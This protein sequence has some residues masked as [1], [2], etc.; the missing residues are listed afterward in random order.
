MA[1]TGTRRT[2]AHMAATNGPAGEGRTG[3]AADEIETSWPR[4]E[5]SRW[6]RQRQT[7]AATILVLMVGVGTV[8]GYHW[9]ENRDVVTMHVGPFCP[10]V[11][12][13]GLE[14]YVTYEGRTSG[15]QGPPWSHSVRGTVKLIKDPLTRQPAVQFTHEGT[16]VVLGPAMHSC[17]IR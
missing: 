7:A 14:G 3:Q 11:P 10:G 6:A 13:F 5:R 8:A 15:V 1:R 9:Y 2:M 12:Q 17:P 16:S 4:D